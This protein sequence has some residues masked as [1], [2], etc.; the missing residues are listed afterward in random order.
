ME[1]FDFQEEKR[2]LINFFI[3][4]FIWAWILW[5]PRIFYSYGIE[6]PIILLIL[7][8][9]AVFAPS[10]AAFVLTFRKSGGQGAKDLFKRGW[11]FKFKKIWLIPIILLPLA[12]SG[13]ALLITSLIQS[14]TPTFSDPFFL[15]VNLI[16]MFFIGGPLAEE[17]GWRG[18]A[19]D[20]LQSKFNALVSSLILGLIWGLWHLPLF[21]ITGTTQSFLPWYEY[22]IL[23]VTITITYT[24]FHNNTRDLEGNPN[25]IVSMLYHLFGNFSA[26]VFMYWTTTVGRWIGWGF[27]LLLVLIVIGIWGYK[28]LTKR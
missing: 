20:R 14:T 3:F 11:T 26:M 12:I 21:F 25:I 18:Y 13:L 17:Y 4:A 9:F 16:I 19:L 22:L 8:E 1:Q 27:N 7:G 6:P 23:Q 24:W 2:N 15:L 28:T 10:I 5:T